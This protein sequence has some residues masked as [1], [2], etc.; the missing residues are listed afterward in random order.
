MWKDIHDFCI[1]KIHPDILAKTVCGMLTSFC[2]KM[3]VLVQV[4]LTVKKELQEEQTKEKEY[5][6]VLPTHE[7]N[8][9]GNRVAEVLS[10]KVEKLFCLLWG[11]VR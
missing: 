10:K 3:T 9:S 7:V 6:T 1:I 5:V 4:V 2:Y 8:L 11:E